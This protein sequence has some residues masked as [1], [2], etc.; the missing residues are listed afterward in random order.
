MTLSNLSAAY[1][2]T[3]PVTP[4]NRNQLAT[5][6]ALYDSLWDSMLN[7]I[8]E[9]AAANGVTDDYAVLQAALTYLGTLTSGGTL[10][11]PRGVYYHSAPLKVPSKVRV[12]G[13]GAGLSVLLAPTGGSYATNVAENG[14]N[15]YASIGCV[16]RNHVRFEGFTVDHTTNALAGNGIVAIPTTEFAGT[17]CTDI[18]IA[19]CEVLGRNSSTG[20]L[21]WTMRGQR[22]KIT[23]NHCDGTYTSIDGTSTQEG[24]EVFGG[25]EVQVTGNSVRR[26]GNAGINLGA[27]NN[28]ADSE[29]VGLIVANN[30][31]E[32]C[33]YG[34]YAG[35]AANSGTAQNIKHSLIESN[36]IRNSYT[37]GI[38]LSR[39]AVAGTQF[40]NVRV[41]GNVIDAAVV[42]IQCYGRSDE[43]ATNRGVTIEDNVVSNATTTALGGIAIIYEG[44]A[45]VRGN[46]VT[47]GSGY[48]IYCQLA[49]DLVISGNT[50]DQV[51]KSGGYVTD[52]DRISVENNTFKGHSLA[53]A[54]TYA[55]L[56]VINSDDHVV[57]GNKFKRATGY[58]EVNIAD[59]CARG[60]LRKNYKLYDSAYA[61]PWVN[62]SVGGTTE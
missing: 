31:I 24:I 28:Y 40:Y 59:T 34:V 47:D 45:T 55:G 42:G 62:S 57:G 4:N 19:D 61:T 27:S 48:G 41:A 35:T 11:M 43:T 32:G 44:N 22:V 3:L 50:V 52:C 14:T 25:Y 12:V 38:R 18:T 15:M 1:L 26:I 20:Y 30:N 2:G 56:L 51:Q 49:N 53:G 39:Q 37:D 9:G 16:G 58:T 7:A 54:Q 60:T 23:G 33:N 10:Y 5:R 13:A 6:L 36:T 46:T 8:A 17:V 21:I 29:C